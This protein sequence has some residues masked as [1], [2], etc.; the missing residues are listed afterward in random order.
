MQTNLTVYFQDNI[1]RLKLILNQIKQLE[2]PLKRKK[3]SLDKLKKLYDSGFIDEI[4]YKRASACISPRR[5]TQ[6]PCARSR[7]LPAARRSP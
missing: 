7:G 5:R 2:K 1:K 3:D 4:E 6:P